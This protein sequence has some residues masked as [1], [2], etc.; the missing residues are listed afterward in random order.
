MRAFRYATLVLPNPVA[1]LPM[2]GIIVARFVLNMAHERE[3][4]HTDFS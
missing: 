4:G 3:L 2:Q 1:I